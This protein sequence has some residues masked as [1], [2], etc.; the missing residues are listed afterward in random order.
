MKKK[1]AIIFLIL[2]AICF[3]SLTAFAAYNRKAI[4]DAWF[5]YDFESGQGNWVYEHET[6]KEVPISENPLAA[7][8]YARIEQTMAILTDE[9]LDHVHPNPDDEYTIRNLSETF[10][11]YWDRHN[12][13]IG[14]T[15]IYDYGIEG[16]EDGIW[17]ISEAY[18]DLYK[19]E[20]Y[21][22]VKFIDNGDSFTMVTEKG[23]EELGTYKKVLGYDTDEDIGYSGDLNDYYGDGGGSAGGGSN[24]GTA[25]GNTAVSS[26]NE[27]KP[28]TALPD[29]NSSKASAASGTRS[30]LTSSEDSTEDTEE[31]YSQ[32]T[33]TRRQTV[34]GSNP[35]VTPEVVSAVDA[36]KAAK[37][38]A[39]NSAESVTVTA[40]HP[41]QQENTV[42]NIV[43]LI[44]VLALIALAV[45]Y[46]KSRKKSSK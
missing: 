41:K 46:L 4:T 8:N 3:S 18:N 43:I 25:N 22:R 11:G 38:A 24:G 44:V 16:Y 10:W 9:D 28:V 6:G 37:E 36:A 34:S 20:K 30:Y 1:T 14:L 31:I 39:N 17:L 29:P 15:L 45:L 35:P 13:D 23:N 26:D 2:F 21:R 12:I 7:M 19:D 5:K 33:A 32:T 42:M 40:T 27:N